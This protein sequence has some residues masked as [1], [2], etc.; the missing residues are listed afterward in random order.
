MSNYAMTFAQKAQ[1]MK[2]VGSADS[3]IKTPRSRT[4]FEELRENRVQGIN[5]WMF[6]MKGLIT[7]RA[8]Q[9]KR[10]WIMYLCMVSNKRKCFSTCEKTPLMENAILMSTG[11][12]SNLQC[13]LCFFNTDLN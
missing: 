12:G 8:I 4:C 7:K 3:S 1:M 6:H 10:N 2:R 13:I 11:H 5:L 9:T